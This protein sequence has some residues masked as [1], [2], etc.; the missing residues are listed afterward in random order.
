MGIIVLDG[1]YMYTN[2]KDYQFN[3]KARLVSPVVTLTGQRQKCFHFFYLMHGAEVGRLNVYTGSTDGTQ[4]DLVWSRTGTQGIFYLLGQVTI[5]TTSM[6]IVEGTGSSGNQGDIAIDDVSLVDGAC[7]SVGAS[8]SA[9]SMACDFE[10]DD[11]CGY[12]NAQENDVDWRRNVNFGT[13]GDSLDHTTRTVGGAFMAI[14][15]YV[16]QRGSLRSPKIMAQGMYCV[17]FF[18]REHGE[19]VG[20]PS[21]SLLDISKNTIN[22]LW[23]VEVNIPVDQWNKAQIS[24]NI[25]SVVQLSF[26]A[27]LSDEA[28]SLSLD[29]VSVRNGTCETPPDCSFDKYD[30]CS[31]RNDLT[32]DDF[33]WEVATP[34][35]DAQILAPWRD[36]D[37]NEHGGFI[38]LDM[39]RNPNNEEAYLVSEVIPPQDNQCFRFYYYPLTWGNEFEE[40]PVHLHVYVSNGAD[41]PGTL[42]WSYS[43]TKHATDFALG[44]LPLQMQQSYRI[45]IGGF[46]TLGQVLALDKFTLLA[47]N[48][49]YSPAESEPPPKVVTSTG[50][51]TTTN[52]QSSPSHSTGS[53]ALWDC[54]FET[55]AC[56][57][58]IGSDS[59]LR[60][61]SGYYLNGPHFDHTKGP[62]GHGYYMTLVTS[63][64]EIM[65]NY[66]LQDNTNYC[67][68]FWIYLYGSADFEFKVQTVGTSSAVL[69]YKYGSMGSDWHQVILDL[70][71]HTDIFDIQFIYE[72]MS[73]GNLNQLALDDIQVSKGKCNLEGKYHLKMYFGKTMT[74][75]KY[76]F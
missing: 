9:S 62:G 21:V 70:P 27:I 24:V 15:G 58:L 38:L 32:H 29:D 35:S 40:I 20:M 37:N 12:T 72:Q 71:Q 54:D 48:C 41:F 69:F 28:G 67:F 76:E 59:W 6:V 66:A 2:S 19:F 1:Y 31:W 11:I 49:S 60:E 46:V 25:S 16:N 57:W 30:L 55:D 52:K 18:Y 51:T 33:D 34:D 45:I 61:Q 63:S 75:K 43:I 64:G 23:F 65:T 39:A 3:Q 22:Q 5:N 14:S 56:H 68:I 4:S 42:S 73:P 53:H 17:S 26:D 47:N 7:T 13:T 8:N 50:T 10:L 36:A 44:Q 74:G